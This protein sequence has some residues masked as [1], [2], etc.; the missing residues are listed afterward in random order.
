[1][2]CHCCLQHT[3]TESSDQVR[4]GNENIDFKLDQYVGLV[5]FGLTDTM[6]VSVAIPIERVS[7]GVTV[8]GNQY[9]V[10][11]TYDQQGNRRIPRRVKSRSAHYATFVRVRQRNRRRDRQC[12]ENILGQERERKSPSSLQRECSCGFPAV[13]H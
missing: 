10:L 2:Q 4:C 11:A 6:D 12:Q 8:T 9:F 5:T 7:L 13:M 3:G 1:M